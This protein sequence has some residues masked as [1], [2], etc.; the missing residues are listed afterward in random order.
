MFVLR[1]RRWTIRQTR[2]SGRH[3]HQFLSRDR[4]KVWRGRR[5]HDLPGLGQHGPLPLHGPPLWLVHFMS[6]DKIETAHWCASALTSTAPPWHTRSTTASGQTPNSCGSIILGLVW[7]VWRL[8]PSSRSWRERRS[9]STTET[10]L[11]RLR[12]GTPDLLRHRHL[13]LHYCMPES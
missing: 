11:T 12:P 10:T 5:L 8:E 13:L 9:S 7:D 3:D 1:C 6:R 2:S 4:L